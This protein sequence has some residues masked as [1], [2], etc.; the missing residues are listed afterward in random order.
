[1][2]YAAVST[3]TVKSPD[4]SPLFLVDVPV[5]DIT[6]TIGTKL[7]MAV[8]GVTQML[9]TQADA[10]AQGTLWPALRSEVD[11]ATAQATA[12]AKASAS[13]LAVGVGVALAALALGAFALRRRTP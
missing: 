4:G 2:S 9:L 12:E 10:Y 7:I 8:P 11:R 13:K 6:D 5:E 3:L 1:M